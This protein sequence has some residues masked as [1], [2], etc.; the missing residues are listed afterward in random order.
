[1]TPQTTPSTFG[2][3]PRT[4]YTR[5]SRL[6]REFMPISHATLWRWVKAGKFPAPVKL[7]ERVTAWRNEDL[8]SWCPSA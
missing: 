4:G 7:G 3:L 5:Q 2:G 6:L 1:M 8:H